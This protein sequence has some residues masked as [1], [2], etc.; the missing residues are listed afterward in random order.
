MYP[1]WI[2]RLTLCWVYCPPGGSKAHVYHFVIG[3]EVEVKKGSVAYQVLR[4]IWAAKCP[5]GKKVVVFFFLG[6]FR[7]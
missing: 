3:G 1:L 5:C 7:I 4:E 6:Q 2:F